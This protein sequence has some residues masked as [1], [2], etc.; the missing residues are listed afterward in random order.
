[1]SCVTSRTLLA[2]VGVRHKNDAIVVA[3][4]MNFLNS[5]VDSDVVVVTMSGVV[6]EYELKISRGDF[7]RDAKKK[8]NRIYSG[9]LHGVKPN[10]Y[11]YVTA[12]GIVTDYDIPTWAGWYEYTPGKL[13]LRKQAPW[14]N[15][16]KLGV[17]VI[18]KLARAMRF[19]VRPV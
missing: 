17:K 7:M 15:R 12:P 19:R 13:V 18:L 6:L 5:N 9:E 2:S 1:M 11:W 3:N 14:L 16:E 4:K 10:K 8:R